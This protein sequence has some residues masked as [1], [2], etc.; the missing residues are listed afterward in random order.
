M[1]RSESWLWAVA[2][3]LMAGAAAHMVFEAVSARHTAAE[4]VCTWE[5]WRA[6]TT[7]SGRFLLEEE[8][9]YAPGAFLPTAE[10]GGRVG[11]GDTL[12]LVYENDAALHRYQKAARLHEEAAMLREIRE[13]DDPAGERAAL[14]KSL[15]ALS[16]A[17]ARG[18]ATDTVSAGRVLAY[19]LT[20]SVEYPESALEAVTAAGVSELKAEKSGFFTRKAEEDAAGRLITAQRWAYAAVLPEKEREKLAALDQ[21]TLILPNGKRLAARLSFSGNTAVFRGDTGLSDIPEPG[22]CELSLLSFEAEG[23][24]LPRSALREDEAGE[25]VLRAGL[26][27]A[28]AAVERIAEKG[29]Y[30]MLRSAELREGTRVVA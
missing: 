18:R 20:E 11:V 23:L 29:E 1:R 24:V 25:Y 3:L 7:L 14:H 28:R 21:A 2:L 27:P 13:A 16:T 26:L 22:V 30:V 4:A 10:E 17:L 12:G 6:E 15:R 19:C 5:T 9:I 8:S